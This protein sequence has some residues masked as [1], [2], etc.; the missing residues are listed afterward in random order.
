VEEA[1]ADG[2]L[3]FS[4][5]LNVDMLKEAYRSGIF[6]WPCEERHVLWFAP[7]TRA[8]LDF[9]DFKVSKKLLRQLSKEGFSSS[10]NARFPEVLENC[11]GQPRPGQ[12]GTWITAKIKDAYLEFH[13]AGYVLSVETLGPDGS[14]Q[15]GLYGVRM[16]RYFSGES[17]FHKASG[18][19]KFALIR[20]VEILRA[21]GLTWL[22]AQ[23]MTPLLASF[24]AKEISREE[25][26]RR[27]AADAF[28]HRA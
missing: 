5:D 13:R 10:T 28:D 26:M 21:E 19:S 14:L 4:Y 7:P 11:A 1:D 22:D 6:P 2:L 17:M 9:A 12:D 23:T 16:G 8:V 3:A 25:Y 24:G 18:A 27:V 15:G 20:L